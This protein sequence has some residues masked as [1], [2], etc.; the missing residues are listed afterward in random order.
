MAILNVGN[1]EKKTTVPCC[2]PSQI[3]HSTKNVSANRNTQDKI[4]I[5]M[6]QWIIMLDS[7]T[8]KCHGGKNIYF[9][10]EE[11]GGKHLLHVVQ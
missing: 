5:K 11:T 6:Q 8:A 1:K 10:Q 9:L 3:K 7:E 2:L 4:Q